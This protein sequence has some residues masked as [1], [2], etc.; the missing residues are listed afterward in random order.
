MCGQA[1]GKIEHSIIREK[2]LRKNA[3]IQAYTTSALQEL[4]QLQRAVTALTA[5]YRQSRE[6]LLVVGQYP[7]FLSVLSSLWTWNMCCIWRTVNFLLVG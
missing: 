5:A 6:H 4:Y 2:E 7:G 3:L 1:I